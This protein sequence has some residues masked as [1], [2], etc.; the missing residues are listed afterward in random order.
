M[1][2]LKRVLTRW[3]SRIAFT[4]SVAAV[5]LIHSSQPLSE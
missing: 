5:W 1:A 4:M 2:R 3:I